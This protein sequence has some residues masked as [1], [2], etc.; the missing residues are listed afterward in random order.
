VGVGLS[1]EGDRWRWCEFNVLVLAREGRRR[2]EVLPEDE[3]EP[4]SSY[5]LHV[6]EV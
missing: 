5:L 1:R 4:A 2:D 3:A 6:K